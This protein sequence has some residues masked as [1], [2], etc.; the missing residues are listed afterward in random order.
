MLMTGMRISGRMSVGVERSTN[1]V[2]SR[3]ISAIT[4]YV[5]G[6]RS[7]MSTSHMKKCPDVV[8]RLSGSPLQ[9]HGYCDAG[10][11]HERA[12]K[13]KAGNDVPAL[14]GTALGGR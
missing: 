11:W 14:S 7:A 8:S 9:R 3:I 2:A 4:I 1:G 6:R 12:E 10:L 13:N 5:S